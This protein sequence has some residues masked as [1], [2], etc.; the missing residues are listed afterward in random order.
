MSALRVAAADYVA[1]RRGLGFV[2]KGALPQLF[3]FVDY[4]EERGAGHLTTEL[5][6]AWATRPQGVQ[7]MWWHQRLALVRG[8]AS[9]LRNIDPDT[10]VPSL[11]LLPATAVRVTPYLY[12][13]ADIAA[14]MAAAR[15]LSPALRAGTYAALIGLLTVSG[16]RIGEAIRLDRA[17]LDQDGQRLLVLHSKRDSSREVP[18]HETT[19]QALSRY[20]ELRDR[21]FPRPRSQSLFVSIR[22]TRL[23]QSAVNPTFRQ[24]VARVGLEARGPRCSPRIHDLRH[25]FAVDTLIG[26][27]RQ[28]ADVDARLALL[29]QVLGHVD[30]ASTYWYLQAV[31]E[32]MALV[33]QRMQD[34]LGDLP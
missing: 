8:F 17:D 14:L 13:D 22:G 24:L 34:V 5:A 12:S 31:P 1:L 19:I 6:L 7:P 3:D 2:L 32:L 28:G 16:L 9:H 33:A 4:L 20:A 30:P 25:R 23:C 26:W 11:D 21:H 15:G 10:E 27:Y 18:L 29:S